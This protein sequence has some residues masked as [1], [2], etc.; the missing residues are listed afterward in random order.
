MTENKDG[1]I[2]ITTLLLLLVLTVMGIAGLGSSS[3]EN[4]L[5]GNVRLRE[6][7]LAKADSGVEICTALIERAV[8]EQDTSGFSGLISPS[9]STSDSNYLP[10]E[11]RSSAFDSDTQDIEFEVDG[12]TLTVDVDKMYSKWMGGT[13]IEFA[14][15]YEGVGKSGGSGFYTYYRLNASGSD[16]ATSSAQVG[17]IYRYVP[18]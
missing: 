14:G 12:Q 5:S 10:N 17:E 16:L 13:A 2:L 6:K 11:L 15:G 8:R 1:Y 9:Y 7:N 4:I 3:L 18:K